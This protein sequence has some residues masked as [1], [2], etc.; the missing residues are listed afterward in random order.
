MSIKIGTFNILDPYYAVK[1]KEKEGIVPGITPPQSNW[2]PST[3]NSFS[4]CDEVANV[5]TGSKLDVIFLQEV[6]T[7][8]FKDLQKAFQKGEYTAVHQIRPDRKDGLAIIFKTQKFQGARLTSI[9]KHGIFAMHIQL[10]KNDGSETFLVANC[11]LLGGGDQ[12]KGTEQID[13]LV[14][15]I[16]PLASRVNTTIVAG[17]FNADQHNL[18]PNP[19]QR[20][21]P[22]SKFSALITAGFMRDDNVSPSEV[23]SKRHIDWIWVNK[24]GAQLKAIAVAQTGLASDHLLV[25]TE[26]I[27]ASHLEQARAGV[28]QF[29]A[30][31]LQGFQTSSS[32]NIP[33]YAQTAYTPPS[34][35]YTPS[36]TMHQVSAPQYPQ[37]YYA[38][39]PSYYPSVMPIQQ[40]MAAS[41]SF[42]ALSALSSSTFVY[43]HTQGTAP[44]R[45]T[46]MN[47]FQVIGGSDQSKKFIYNLL[48]STL[49]ECDQMYKQDPSKTFLEY[50]CLN[51]RKK[52]SDLPIADLGK[53][54]LY[55][56]FGI[57]IARTLKVFTKNTSQHSQYPSQ[58]PGSSAQIMNNFFIIG[59]A[60][61]TEE[62]KRLIWNSLDSALH[63]CIGIMQQDPGEDFAAILRQY[64]KELILSMPYSP[65]ERD[66]IFQAFNAAIDLASVNE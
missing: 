59:M 33:A 60:H 14:S 18:P 53:I 35:S 10:T 42:Q 44:F 23:R 62:S 6:S 38:P 54:L 41:P 29:Q 65:E 22:R 30:P 26:I 61:Q 11:H 52:I 25:A 28:S 50:L 56:A 43:Q 21:L 9:D 32:S 51:F 27:S 48:D 64:Y 15:Q 66:L 47:H 55:K 3:K 4:R 34:Y 57:A 40:Q 16:I 13:H 24:Q 17:D 39:Q 31:Q 36:L 46:I 12:K 7:E 2:K 37:P 19:N 8:S 63:T 5:I 1:W 49:H 20:P 45:S 58:N